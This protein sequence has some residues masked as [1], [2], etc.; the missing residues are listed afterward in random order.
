MRRCVAT[1][2]WAW[3]PPGKALAAIHANTALCH[4][5]TRRPIGGSTNT[6]ASTSAPATARSSASV[7]RALVAVI[8]ERPRRHSRVQQ[9]KEIQ[10]CM[11][12]S[13]PR[14][15]SHGRIP[16]PR[17]LSPPVH[18]GWTETQN[19]RYGA[20]GG[21][22]TSCGQATDTS[23]GGLP[24]ISTN[25]P[26]DPRLKQPERN[27]VREQSVAQRSR[28]RPSGGG[29]GFAVRSLEAT[30][31]SRGSRGFRQSQIDSSVTED[32]GVGLDAVAQS[33]QSSDFQS[34]G[35]RLPAVADAA[36]EDFLK[37][38]GTRGS[39]RG[40]D[41][42]Q[43]SG[44]SKVSTFLDPKSPEC[45]TGFALATPQAE[46]AEVHVGS[47][48]TYGP[49]LA[50]EL[51]EMRKQPGQPVSIF[52]E[53]DGTMDAAAFDLRQREGLD[54]ASAL[55]STRPFWQRK[56]LQRRTDWDLPER[57]P[58]F[59][60]ES[61]AHAKKG[62]HSSSSEPRRLGSS[63]QHV[64]D[65]GI[66]RQT[67]TD[68]PK[69]IKPK[70]SNS[71]LKNNSITLED[72]MSFRRSSWP[73]YS[74]SS[75]E[76]S[77][78]GT[79]SRDSNGC[80][81]AVMGQTDLEATSKVLLTDTV[82][83]QHCIND[84]NTTT[85]HTHPLAPKSRF[86]SSLL[87]RV[88]PHGYCNEILGKVAVT[89]PSK[90]DA[91]VSLKLKD[92]RFI[93]T[94][95]VSIHHEH[96]AP[97]KLWSQNDEN[98]ASHQQTST[99]DKSTLPPLLE[100]VVTGQETARD[101]Q[102]EK[103]QTPN[104]KT[105]DGIN[106]VGPQTA[107]G[108]DITVQFANS[109][110]A[111]ST[112]VSSAISR[113]WASAKEKEVP[114]EVREVQE[115]RPV[116]LQHVGKVL[117]STNMSSLP[118]ALCAT[119]SF[120]GADSSPGSDA[121]SCDVASPMEPPSY[122]ASPNL[123]SSLKRQAMSFAATGVSPDEVAKVS[124]LLKFYPGIEREQKKEQLALL[125]RTSFTDLVQS[126]RAS[127][128]NFTALVKALGLRGDTE[129]ALKVH[130]DMK[131]HGY[132]PTE[133]TYIALI[134]GA[135][136]K[137][138]AATARL[139]YLKM[140][141]NLIVPTVKSYAALIHAHAVTGDLTSGF[142]LLRKLED[143]GLTP[144]CVVYTCLIDGLVT[145]K[146]PRLDKAW[147]TFWDMRT[148]KAIEPDEVLFTVMIKAC[149][150]RKEAEKALNILDEMRSLGQHPT[151][152]TYT[153]LIHS[154]SKRSDFAKKCWDF[155]YQMK[156]E[157]M[158][159]PI[160]AFEHL[161][162]ACATIGSTSRARTVIRE[163]GKAALEL[164]PA[165]YPTLLAV[166]SAAM[167]LPRVSDFERVAHVQHAW[168]VIRD[169]RATGIPTD[170]NTLNAL[171]QVYVNGGFAQHAIDMLQQF[172]GFNCKPNEHSFEMLLKMLKSDLHDVG[173]FFALWDYMRV[174]T[175]VQPSASMLHLSL[176][177]ALESRQAPRTIMALREMMQRK[178][179]PT[180]ALTSQLSRVGRQITEVHT[181][182]EQMIQMQ[183]AEVYET[184]FRLQKRIESRI[185]EHQLRL[186]DIGK[187]E[188][189]LTE[190]QSARKKHYAN[191][192]D[193]F[194]TRDVNSI[195]LS[196]QN[197]RSLKKRGGDY[198]AKVK[199]RPKPNAIGHA[200]M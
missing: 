168:S 101:I 26:A 184:Q 166:F 52:D 100:S 135:T 128:T 20:L 175:S 195:A 49:G 124:D 65:S 154:C 57:H 40:T 126:D 138:D 69:L 103:Q 104:C 198:Y 95:L 197:I 73:T 123:V 99:T 5:T 120:S 150:L 188:D 131:I 152:I 110:E 19:L 67:E 8:P 86:T 74:S 63:E 83:N 190:E 140:R 139:F 194:G 116:D 39:S 55:D 82:V 1:T 183:K 118:R 17:Q 189:S 174:S 35:V 68:H 147:R 143:E 12:K 38:G 169:M 181:M 9:L 90:S 158:T 136:V 75:A 37:T 153:E 48:E 85:S 21:V 97:G 199:D 176:S 89:D 29:A 13:T 146:P 179:Y 47:P 6:S 44:Q 134:Q 109:H 10:Q 91:D 165:M 192:K 32:R 11:K 77:S 53:D 14:K 80:A 160:E 196:K 149:A 112:V 59:S 105:H 72:P 28:R 27:N 107:L 156:A 191:V 122:S 51:L 64:K 127:V 133:D 43:R 56:P 177:A 15:T 58:P 92:V 172:N 187:T 41:D 178:V 113:E 62:K 34:K 173:R 114:E 23:G 4:K 45:L 182:V 121:L 94:P 30:R 171:M 125:S 18:D 84:P 79:T 130:N 70:L 66:A 25:L 170:T 87:K 96:L 93:P 155:Y 42:S 7:S 117:S 106:R 137:K 142:A 102:T 151:H 3:A 33:L 54:K 193:K 200:A 186:F 22:T 148:W 61:Q 164:S 16:Q 31:Q 115:D 36:A 76:P 180:P 24:P 88:Q 46:L 167:Q 141:S 157:D 162:Q 98:E 50:S 159:I 185:D 81:A 144:D 129:G 163:T 78:A 145:Q 2:T 119:A 71:T 132:E 111:T 161:L 60:S 108:K